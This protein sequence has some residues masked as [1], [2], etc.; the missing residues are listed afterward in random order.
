MSDNKD[1]FVLVKLGN[2]SIEALLDQAEKARDASEILRASISEVPHYR[3][4]TSTSVEE[5]KAFVKYLDLMNSFVDF[6]DD[7]IQKENMNGS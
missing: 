1:G 3:S 5:Q 7:K 6:L 2:M 4:F